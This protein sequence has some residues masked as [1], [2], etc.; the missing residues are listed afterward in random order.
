MACPVPCRSARAPGQCRGIGIFGRRDPKKNT[1]IGIS[2]SLSSLRASGF[3]VWEQVLGSHFRF[4][5]WGRYE[6]RTGILQMAWESA[7][8]FPSPWLPRSCFAAEHPAYLAQNAQRPRRASCAEDG[9]IQD[10]RW[11]PYSSRPTLSSLA[12]LMLL[13]A[14]GLGSIA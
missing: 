9:K 11:G 4:V 1:I 8:F 14:M 12:C 10:P 2:A 7:A 6:L 13:T 3:L 5:P